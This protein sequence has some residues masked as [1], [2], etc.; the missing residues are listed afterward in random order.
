M[1]CPCVQLLVRYLPL[2][3]PLSSSN[4]LCP[5]IVGQLLGREGSSGVL[6]PSLCRMPGCGKKA[7]LTITASS[8]GEWWDNGEFPTNRKEDGEWQSNPSTTYQIFMFYFIFIAAKQKQNSTILRRYQ[9]L[10]YSETVSNHHD[11]S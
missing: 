5:N 10:L 9:G 1:C 3:G 6:G 7:E 8:E 4:L 2:G 11:V